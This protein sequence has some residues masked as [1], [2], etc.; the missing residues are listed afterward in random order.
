MPREPRVIAKDLITILNRHGYFEPR[1]K[2]EGLPLAPLAD[3]A[4]TSVKTLSKLLR[5]TWETIELGLADR[6]CVAV[7]SNVNECG[8]DPPDPS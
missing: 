8:F 4:E 7:G 5:G 6:L 2:R 1:S 3:S